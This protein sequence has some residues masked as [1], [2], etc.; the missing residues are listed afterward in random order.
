VVQAPASKTTDADGKQLVLISAT[1][2]S[3]DVGTKF[4]A[5]AVPVL[6]WEQAVQDDFLMTGNTD[7]VDRG[8]ITAQTDINIVNA[9]HPLAGGLTAGTHTV[10]SSAMDVGF[11]APNSNAVVVATVAGD[12]TKAVIYGYDTG[13]KLV[14]GTTLAP[15][16]RVMFF[17]SNDSFAAFTPDA[18][19]LF[20]AAVQW[21]SG[22][23]PK[24]PKTSA[25]IA[26]VSFHSAD[27]KPS[28]NAFNAGFTNAPDADYTKLLRAN[29]H[30]VTRF[31]TTAAPDTNVLNTFD[32]VIISRSVPS[33]D[34]QTTN[35][36]AA[37][38]G[39]TAP[40]MILGG[41]VI[42]MNRLGL[43]SGN[44]IPDIATPITL[45]VTDTNHPIFAGIQL[46]ANNAMANTYANIAAF[47]GTPQRGISVVME[48]PAGGGEVLATVGTVGDPAAGG[49][50]I[51]EWEAGA[52]MANTTANVLGSHRLIFL[53]GSREANGFTSEG[54]GIFD[55]TPDG[56]K[57]FLNAVNYMAG[58]QPSAAPPDIALARDASGAIKITFTGTLQASDT[59]DGDFT[60]VVGAT[61]PYTVDTLT[62]RMKF[63]RTKR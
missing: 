28:L 15:A 44:T 38:N 47:K 61:N 8:T 42:R 59:V 35:A 24:P 11:G 14:D 57:M 55:L 1:V 23:G 12:A 52:T 45:S 26:W 4:R 3:G 48:P 10:T 40:T 58:V 51:A 31:L 21:A 7:T 13:A 56:T 6:S 63:F 9:T 25:N 32:L 37:W 22:I 49:T 54:A 34:Y 39:L 53:T 27:D 2:S 16:R 41:Y 50:V 62:D 5:S 17:P 60:D 20:D 18:L 33:G 19:K 43:M 29:G 46:D 30:Q 36:T